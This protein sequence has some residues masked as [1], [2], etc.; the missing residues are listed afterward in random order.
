MKTAVNFPSLWITLILLSGISGYGFWSES[1]FEQETWSPVGLDRLAQVGTVYMLAAVAVYFWKPF[2]AT[3]LFLLLAAL[4]SFAAVG[5]LAL[6]CVLFFLCSSFLLGRLLFP[7]EGALDDLLALLLGIGIWMLLIGAAAHFPV[8]TPLTYLAALSIPFVVGRRLIRPGLGTVLSRFRPQPISLSSYTALLLLLFVV[9][10]HYLAAL[11]PE[12]SHDGLSMHMVIA[13]RLAAHSVWP[14]DVQEFVWAVMP[15]GGD[16]AFCGVYML[17]GEYAARLLNLSFFLMI[18]GLVFVASRRWLPLAGA[19][20]LTALFATTPLVQLVTGSLFVENVWAVFVTAAV[21]SLWKYHATHR[22]AYFVLAGVFLGCSMQVKYGSW[23]LLPAALS[24][25]VVEWK[26][27]RRA[28]R[29]SSVALVTLPALLIVFA[30]P[31]YLTAFVETGNPVY[32]FLN[33]VFQS[34]YFD[35]TRALRDIRWPVGLDWSTPYNIT[36]RS[37]R[38]LESQAGSFGFQ[39]LL[40]LP[41]SILLLLRRRSYLAAAALGIGLSY[42]LL[43]CLYITYLRYLYPVLPLFMIVIAWV[44]AELRTREIRLYRLLQVLAVMG[45]FLNGYF[46]PTAGWAHR[47]LYLNLF[48]QGEV[49]RYIEK[50]APQRPLVEYLNTQVPGAKVAFFTDGPQIAPLEAAAVGGSWHFPEF[51]KR[52][53]GARSAQ[54]LYVLMEELSIEYFVAPTADNPLHF[55]FPAVP[56]FLQGYTAPEAFS[57]NFYLARLDRT[58]EPPR[59]ADPPHTKGSGAYDNTDS[60]IRYIGAWTFDNQFEEAANGTIVY[61]NNPGD[62]FRFQFQGGEI[63]W[64]YTKA[65]SRGM[66]AVSIDGE[67]KETVDLYSSDIHWQ[68]RTTLSGLSDSEHVLEVRVLEDKHSDATDRF[69]DVDQIIVR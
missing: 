51:L 33:N 30:A 12:V 17:G 55:K 50:R 37:G 36:F 32:P 27:A 53:R 64:V 35:A 15:M 62:S 67:E 40:F 61:S 9:L 48:D 3:P 8:N 56:L 66:A 25:V 34:P 68:S 16:W 7:G 54:D 52:L 46:I 2:F 63:S 69:V 26:R 19:L 45:I 28:G 5:P 14:F 22:T 31:P 24:L 65:F 29:T 42:A 20:L 47:D 6:L 4:Y 57:R 58:I 44:A 18:A 13:S 49:A 38:Y 60:S 11:K 23:A 21:L 1:L 39:Y 41:L 10:I 43:T 59:P